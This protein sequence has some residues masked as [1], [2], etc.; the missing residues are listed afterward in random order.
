LVGEPSPVLGNRPVQDDRGAVRRSGPAS[1]TLRGNPSV[2]AAP[3]ATS[4]TRRRST[5]TGLL[6]E[7]ISPWFDRWFLERCRPPSPGYSDRPTAAPR[8]RRFASWLAWPLAQGRLGHDA[9]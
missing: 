4:P 3:S 5:G 7:K 6:A 8:R 2:S 9:P 1:P